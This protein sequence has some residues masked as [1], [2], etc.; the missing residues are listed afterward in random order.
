MMD[1]CACCLD[2]YLNDLFIAKFANKIYQIECT[3]YARNV[4]NKE[5]N[6]ITF[7]EIR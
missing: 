5:I 2:F 7:L 1:N 6:G 3:M 4:W